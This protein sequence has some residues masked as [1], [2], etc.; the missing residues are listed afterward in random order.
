MLLQRRI[1]RA[2]PRGIDQAIVAATGTLAVTTAGMEMSD[3]E[4]MDLKRYLNVSRAEPEHVETGLKRV[5][6]LLPTELTG[7]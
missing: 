3:R 5:V 7:R 2:A 1:R 4:R 6:D